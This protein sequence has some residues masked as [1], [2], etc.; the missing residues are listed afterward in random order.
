MCSSFDTAE[1]NQK[2]VANWIAEVEFEAGLGSEAVAHLS[3]YFA[4]NL[5][6]YFD[7]NLLPMM[8]LQL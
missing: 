5:D 2:Y 1:R 4:A 7:G 8:D 6:Q 3:P